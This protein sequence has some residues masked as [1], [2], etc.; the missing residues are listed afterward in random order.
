MQLVVD[1][2]DFFWPNPLDTHHFEFDRR[3]GLDQLIIKRDMSGLDSFFNTLD[4]GRSEP[5][6]AFELA[7]A[8]QLFDVAIE[9]IYRTRG[10]LVS[11]H[12]KRI[13]IFFQLE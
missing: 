11:T 13:A 8:G 9:G 4:N 7:F 1:G 10:I 6:H 5:W 12:F 2:I 3:C